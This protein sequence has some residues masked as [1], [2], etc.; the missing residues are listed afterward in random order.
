MSQQANC[1]NCGALLTFKV[2]TSLVAVCDHCKSIVGRGD[3]G[4]ETLGQVA[5]LVQTLSPLEIGTRGSFAGLRFELV[6][7]TQ[8]H[9]PAGGV[10]DE[11]YAAF[12]NNRWGWLAETMGRFFLTFEEPPPPGLPRFDDIRLNERISLDG[13]TLQVAEKNTAT[14]GSMAGEVPRR[15]L[16]GTPHPFADLSGPRSLYGTLDYSGPTPAVYLGREVTLDELGIPPGQRRTYPGL[17]PK[18][19]AVKLNCPNCGG[20]LELRAPDK[21][22]RVGCP[23][24]GSLLDVKDGQLKLMKS[25]KKPTIEPVIPLG[26]TGT[27]LGIEWTCLGFL[28]RVVTFEG[29]DYYWEEYLLYHPRHGFRWLVF[30]DYHWN[31]VE[32]VPPGSVEASGER[33]VRYAG[34]WYRLFQ[35]ARPRVTLVYGECYWKVQVGEEVACYDFVA[36]P[37]SLSMERSGDGGSGEINWSH[38][39]YVEPATVQAMFQLA[40]P[41]PAPPKIGPNQPFPFT[42]VYRQFGWLV[43]AWLVLGVLWWLISP[44]KQI[45]EETIVLPPIAQD[46]AEKTYTVEREVDWQAGRNARISLFAPRSSSQWV[47]VQGVL[48]YDGD[49]PEPG[50]RSPRTPPTRQVFSFWTEAGSQEAVYLSAL[51]AARYKLQLTFGWEKPDQAMQVTM[52]IR[53]GV[54]HATPWVVTLLL[55]AVVPLLLAV[56]QLLWESQRWA[57]SNLEG[58]DE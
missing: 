56:Y 22:E 46:Q 47:G 26:A 30:S 14:V 41:L 15:V 1:P 51:P 44:A 10:W 58:G 21:S 11:W 4:L 55:L 7:R 32:P 28:R 25:L 38:G 8:Y 37:Y 5:D 35:V 36:A 24:C 9:H 50:D 29:I 27:H 33:Y 48:V 39:T 49:V 40:E 43:L 18:I 13:L 42:G 16:P 20:G 3:R 17:E 19:A 45:L 57:E 31:W 34:R 23:Y 6:G 2:G 54:P 53:Q 12:P 52:R